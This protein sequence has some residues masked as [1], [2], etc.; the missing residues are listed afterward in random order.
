MGIY[1]QGARY[2]AILTS[3]IY[4]TMTGHWQ[5]NAFNGS[6][7]GHWP[8]C[9]CCILDRVELTQT[10]QAPSTPAAPGNEACHICWFSVIWHV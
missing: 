9:D 7:R 4:L 6:S 5:Q 8:E 10:G 2:G 1:C 3:L